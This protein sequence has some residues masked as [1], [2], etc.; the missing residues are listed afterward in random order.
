M[1]SVIIHDFRV[2]CQGK[3]LIPAEVRNHDKQSSADGMFLVPVREEWPLHSVIQQVL[4]SN[5]HKLWCS[6]NEWVTVALSLAGPPLSIFIAGPPLMA[7]NGSVTTWMSMSAAGSQKTN[8]RSSSTS[9]PV[10]IFKANKMDSHRTLALLFILF[11]RSLKLSQGNYPLPDNTWIIG[12][13]GGKLSHENLTLQLIQV[14]P[15]LAAAMDR[16]PV[17]LAKIPYTPK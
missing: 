6:L 10:I 8:S 15:N 2:T 1:Q 3:D 11:E 16:G 4:N 17:W 14:V 12:R 13:I 7:R 9:A 5:Q